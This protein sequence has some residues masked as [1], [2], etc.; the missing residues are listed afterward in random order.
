[1]PYSDSEALRLKALYRTQLLDTPREAEFDEITRL[2]ALICQAPMANVTLVDADRQWFK[3]RFGHNLEGGPRSESFCQYTIAND[4]IL[5]VPDALLD[6]RFAD[7]PLVTGEPRVRFYAGYPVTSQDGYR[8]GVLCVMDH[9]PRSLTEIQREA[10]IGLAHQVSRQI[11]LRALHRQVAQQAQYQES[12]LESASCA[13]ICG[14]LDGL[15]TH[16]NKTAE[17]MLG[18]TAQEVLEKATPVLFHDPQ[19]IETRAR[20]LS[21]ELGFE[22]S[23][24]LDV[25][26]ARLRLGQREEREWTYI[27]KD[28]SRL[29][30]WLATSVLHDEQGQVVGYMG[31]AR[32]LTPVK[33]AEDRW[34]DLFDHC[35]DLVQ[36]VSP[37]GAVLFTNRAWQQ[38]LGYSQE[39]ALKL[40]IFSLIPP[41]QQDHCMEL[42]GRLLGGEQVGLVRAALL[43]KNGQRV[44]VEGNINVR[45]EQGQ[46]VSTRAIFRDISE[47]EGQREA[48]ETFNRALLHLREVDAQPHA[49]TE[50]VARALGVERV[51]LWLF[52]PNQTLA[53]CQSAYSLSRA[54]HTTE[55][56]L[57]VAQYPLYFSALHR[58]LAVVAEDAATHPDLQEWR[59]YL[60]DF[61]ILSKLSVAIEMGDRLAGMLCCEQV[62]SPRKWRDTETK[63]V[64]AVV[65]LV[66]LEW[67]Q[68]E[69]RRAE[70]AL[71]DSEERHRLLIHG[72]RDAIMTLH[73]PDWH[74]SVC[75]PAALAL[76]GVDSEQTWKTLGPWNVSP[77]TQPDGR[78]SGEA[79]QQMIARA[80][81]SGSH[82]FEWTHRRLHGES[83]PATVLLTALDLAGERFLQAT[84]RDITDQKKAEETL[85]D[86]NQTLER[87]VVERTAALTESERF[88]RASLDALVQEIAVLDGAGYILA[89]NQAWRLGQEGDDFLDMCHKLAEGRMHWALRASDVIRE[90]IS[91]RSLQGQYEAVL[92]REQGEF[93]FHCRVTRFPGDGPVRVVLAH[94]NVTESLQAQNAMRQAL[95]TLDAIEDAALI[96]DLESLRI[97]FANQGA[98]RQL[99]Y[100]RDELMHLRAVDLEP[101][102]GEILLR[103]RWAPL[104]RQER[105]S[106]Q[107]TTHYR[108]KDGRM[109]P[110]EASLQVDR[111]NPSQ[112]RMIAI[113]RDISERLLR[114]KKERRT[115]RLESLG[116]LAGGVAHDLNN[117]LTPILMSAELLRMEC[118]ESVGEYLDVVEQSARRGADM[119]KQ[120]LTFAQGAEGER[121]PLQLIHQIKD[122]EKIMRSTFDKA[123]RLDCQYDANLHPVVGDATQL[124]QV[125]L[126]LCVNARDAMPGGG[127]LTL[128]AQNFQADA[129]FAAFVADAQPGSYVRLTVRDTGGGIP[130][131]IVDRIFDPFFTTKGPEKGTGLGLSTVLGIAKSHGGFVRVY[132]EVDLGSTFEVYLPAAE[133]SSAVGERISPKLRVGQG[134]WILVVDD[135]H[136]IRETLKRLL[137]RLGYQA[138]LASDGAEAL[139]QFGERRDEIHAILTDINM[140]NL[141]GVSLARSLRRLS[142]ETPIIAMTGL[143]DENRLTQLRDLGVAQQLSKPFSVASL[144]EA[145]RRVLPQKS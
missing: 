124:H 106:L 79:A 141:D 86:N 13:I 76:F 45:F 25:F 52:D 64:S 71:R 18:Y 98:I 112:L 103:E 111:S 61:G 137:E 41:D 140:P 136:A 129:A 42:F 115:Q 87:L 105:A 35:T 65:H 3:A 69:R 47:W 29:P 30:V 133:Q 138:V 100:S 23:P 37:E 93:H 139:L 38:R 34:R 26:T 36:G 55:M 81:E 83:F 6:E 17:E 92:R 118:P 127:T 51:A 21:T 143:H 32:D 8:I 107:V 85:R 94:E 72:S 24:G 117:T 46:P 5:E 16:F 59:D 125:L 99:G 49:V 110:V 33:Q 40:N 67:E 44:E 11:E 82:F 88:V 9:V 66:M 84:V 43:A 135:E 68:G 4:E 131:E 48:Q 28:G 96:F 102:T 104:L 10:L 142:P 54:R 101:E 39:E 12:I 120:L 57:V 91:G 63:F 97:G 89:T 144:A 27:R 74:F 56:P 134:E 75:N 50:T 145:L 62:G 7:K 130:A 116:T 53:T 22:V 128:R 19:E 73:P 20:E 126:N 2:A 95:A 31:L 78:P 15:I 113:V 114:E 80:L 14:G 90:V 60:R 109:L 123:I 121:R 119:V 122:I 58:N 132:S 70:Q 77:E 1:M 108:S